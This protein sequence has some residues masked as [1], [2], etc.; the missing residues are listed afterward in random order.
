MNSH[1]DRRKPE[2]IVLGEI[3][4]TNRDEPKSE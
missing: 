3:F 4:T 2:R 1:F